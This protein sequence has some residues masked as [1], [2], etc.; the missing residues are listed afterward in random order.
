M[1]KEEFLEKIKDTY[2]ITKANQKNP[3]EPHNICMYLAS[4]WYTLCV[5]EGEIPSTDV[6]ASLDVHILQDTVL[7]T[8]LG[9][10]DPRTNNRI[11]FIGGIRGVQELEKLVDSD[12]YKVAFSMFPTQVSD[13]IQVANAKKVMPPKSTWFEPKLRSGLIVHLLD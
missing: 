13:I 3:T 9:I 7:S 4:D 11:N 8:I 5:K 2:K 10:E 1:R 6:V 12:E